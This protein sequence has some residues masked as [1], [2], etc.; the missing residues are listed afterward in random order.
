MTT[1]VQMI[2]L[3][4]TLALI[5]FPSLSHGLFSAF[6]FITCYLLPSLSPF[7]CQG[8]VGLPGE[9]GEIGFQGDKVHLPEWPLICL[10]QTHICTLS[11][12][13]SGR[14]DV[15]WFKSNHLLIADLRAF[16]DIYTCTL[17]HTC[18]WTCVCANLMN[19]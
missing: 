8:D 9:Q 16:M 11:A 3:E 12:Q 4:W 2:R 14:T 10:C 19:I 15:W 7:F 17:S 5:I 1:F 13:S 18:L 6:D